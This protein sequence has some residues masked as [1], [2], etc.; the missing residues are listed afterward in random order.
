MVTQYPFEEA[1]LFDYNIGPIDINSSV[2]AGEYILVQKSFNWTL[3]SEYQSPL[4]VSYFR[5]PF[6]QARF[7]LQSQEHVSQ[8]TYAS[9][10]E[11]TLY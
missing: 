5:Q 9:T 2:W 10:E 1:E 3:Q 11:L 4:W 6:Q 7:P 8:T